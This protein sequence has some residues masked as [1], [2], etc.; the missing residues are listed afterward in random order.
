MIFDILLFDIVK[1]SAWWVSNTSPLAINL[2]LRPAMMYSR[3]PATTMVNSVV[4]LM[5]SPWLGGSCRFLPNRYRS[6]V[7]LLLKLA[8]PAF[9]FWHQDWHTFQSLIAERHLLAG[10]D[11]FPTTLT[12][13]SFQTHT[14]IQTI[15]QSS[16]EQSMTEDLFLSP[17][18]KT[19]E[20]CQHQ[21][22]IYPI[23][24]LLQ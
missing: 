22:H 5:R 16:L 24:P 20:T 12:D 21:P 15:L 19:Q 3:M 6:Y 17:S 7:S 10:L 18:H 9:C 1:I 4:I 13:E 14:D 8:W 11:P 2:R 23:T